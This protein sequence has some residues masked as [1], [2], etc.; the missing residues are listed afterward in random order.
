MSLPAPDRQLR[1]LVADLA[2]ASQEDVDSVLSN[3]SDDH[4]SAVEQ[5]LGSYRSATAPKAKPIRWESLGLSDWLVSRLA[6]ASH[7]G[8]DEKAT[9][10]IWS[11]Y[12]LAFAMTPRSQE[13][14][15]QA[16]LD[17]AARAEEEPGRGQ[18]SWLVRL[19]PPILSGGRR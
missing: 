13:A 3:L 14:L 10:A 17:L 12:D 1:R 9:R 15:L 2:A 7:N 11:R 19:F 5:L 4:R 16:G 18:V 8:G 6:R